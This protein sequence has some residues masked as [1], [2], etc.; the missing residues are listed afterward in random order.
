MLSFSFFIF[1]L[2]SKNAQLLSTRA[3]RSCAFFTVQ[4]HYIHHYVYLILGI[5]SDP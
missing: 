2:Q 4:N 3:E 5:G 1:G